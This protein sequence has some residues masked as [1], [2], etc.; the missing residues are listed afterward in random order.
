MYIGQNS[1]MAAGSTTFNNTALGHNSLQ[2][3]LTGQNNTAVGTNALRDN[4]SGTEN[5]AFGMSALIKN[6]TGTSNTAIGYDS[7]TS[8]RSGGANV[9]LGR[10][11]AQSLSKGSYNVALGNNSLNTTTGSY[12]T[13]L[14]YQSGSSDEDGFSSGN[15]LNNVTTLGAYAISTQSNTVIIGNSNV[16]G[17]NSPAVNVGIGTPAPTNRLSVSPA[18]YVGLGDDYDGGCLGG[19]MSQNGT[20]ATFDTTYCSGIFTAAS[21]GSEIVYSSGQKATIAGFISSSQV[22]VTPAQTVSNTSFKLFYAGLQVTS[23]GTVGV[24][25]VSPSAQLDVRVQGSNRAGLV[26]NSGASTSEIVNIQA[27]GSSVAV[28]A[29]NGSA[30]FMNATNSTTAFRVQG[31]G[32]GTQQK[33]AQATVGSTSGGQVYQDALVGYS[34][35][36]NAN[37][38]ITQLGARY[39]SGTYTVSL[40]EG[41]VPG[42]PVGVLLARTAVSTISGTWQYANLTTPVNVVAG[43]RYSVVIY[44]SGSVSWYRS[45]GYTWDTTSGNITINR[46]VFDEYSEGE[47]SGTYQSYNTIFGMIG[48]PDITFVPAQTLLSVDTTNA[49]TVFGRDTDGTI[50]DFRSGSTVQGTIAVSGSTVSYNAFTGSHYGLFAPGSTTATRGEL[51]D[52][53]GSNQYKQGSAEP[54]YGITRAATA[55][56]PNILGAYLGTTDPSTPASLDNPELIMAAGNGDVWIADNGSGNVMIGDPLISSGDVPGHAMRD[57]KSF[58]TSHIFAKSAEAIDWSTV[59]TTVNGMKVAKVT[60]LFSYYNQDNQNTIAQDLQGGSLNITGNSILNG[61]LSVIGNINVSGT[62]TLATLIV[63]GSVTIQQ[64]LTVQGNTTI[65]GNLT[66]GGKIV[67]S[68]NRPQVAGVSTSAPNLTATVEGTDTAGIVQVNTAVG[69]PADVRI[70]ISYNQAYGGVPVATLSAIGQESAG[71]GMYIVSSDQNEL[72]IGFSNPPAANQIY[73]FSYQVIQANPL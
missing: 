55:N 44:G 54:Y 28:I 59:T 9:A 16:Y 38:S 62:T 3:N 67:T 63:T 57:T 58:P 14:G 11:S 30:T 37:G 32:S 69:V 27:N 31:I 49:K 19:L 50:L 73:R 20:T 72:V 52:L 25:T 21:V 53:T 6:L 36:P 70:R 61:N 10:G 17:I 43:K 41:G 29:N 71:L 68:G 45:P 35:T 23:N 26:V 24:G 12:N 65:A 42:E 7:L 40:Y 34:F 66:V 4:V 33:P 56:S 46:G 22:T 2:Y 64:N 5:T 39:V 60:V 47:L 51:V 15:T 18:Y 13:A 48:Q 8:N 1:G